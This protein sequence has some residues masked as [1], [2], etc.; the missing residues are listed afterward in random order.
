MR[1]QDG[2]LDPDLPPQ[3]RGRERT[4]GWT[5]AFN[6]L[7][8]PLKAFVRGSLPAVPARSAPVDVVPVDYVA[9]AV[10][11][12]TQDPANGT[13]TYHLVAGPRATS[14]G[15]LIELVLRGRAARARRDPAGL[16]RRVMYPVLVRTSDRLRQ[17]LERTKVFFPYFAMEVS[18]ENPRAR[19]R[20]EP[21]GI[22][23]PP[24]ESYFGRL[25]DSR[26]GALGAY[27]RLA[28]RHTGSWARA[29]DT[30]RHL[31]RVLGVPA[32]H[33]GRRRLRCDVRRVGSRSR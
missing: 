28:R 1:E 12:L 31:V 8:S 14:V 29:R 2:L 24:I 33:G 32:R 10:F 25:V 9:D 7:Y 15:R 26:Q 11:E 18:Y 5:P 4:T 3:H 17:G 22:E 23:V 6:V 27:A 21:A 13:S 20:L 30:R 16:F 19:G